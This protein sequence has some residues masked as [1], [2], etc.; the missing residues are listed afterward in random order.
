MDYRFSP[1]APGVWCQFKN[2]ANAIRTT[3]EC[4][5][6]K[7]AVSIR[8]DAAVRKPTVTA[9]GE[10]VDN[11]F[12]LRRSAN[13]KHHEERRGCEH[14]YTKREL[15]PVHHLFAPSK[16]TLW[17]QPNVAAHIN[18]SAAVEQWLQDENV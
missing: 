13:H 7:I 3:A 11:S 2:C 8:D 14:P 9:A 18:T 10:A 17:N 4:C 5:A 1:S 12:A 16:A 15:F 6:I